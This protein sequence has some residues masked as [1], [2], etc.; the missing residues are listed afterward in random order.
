MGDNAFKFAE[1]N[2]I[3]TE[4][5]Y[6][7]KAAKGTC[8]QASC[9]VGLPKGSVTGF[10]DVPV[11]SKEDL[12]SALNQ[13]PVSIAIEADKS[14]FQF[15]KSGVLKGICGALLDHGVLVVGYG[16]EG[17]KDYWLVKNSWGPSWGL[18]GIHQAAS[19]KRRQ[20]R[21]WCAIQGVLSCRFKV[22][23]QH[24]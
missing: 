8:A 10:K 13:Q 9:K 12:M 16:T 5:S 18:K 21:M 17:G 3:C 22:E 2:G 6:A 23:F 7:Y 24:H 19:W 20:W 14:I 4:E 1:A 11:D 15:Y